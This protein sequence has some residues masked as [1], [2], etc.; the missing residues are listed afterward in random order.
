[1]IGIVIAFE[2]LIAIIAVLITHTNNK[3]SVWYF[4]LSHNINNPVL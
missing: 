3:K 4:Y 2:V 1:M